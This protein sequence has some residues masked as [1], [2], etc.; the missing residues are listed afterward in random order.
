[1]DMNY[2]PSKPKGQNGYISDNSNED[3]YPI[4]PNKLEWCKFCVHYGYVGNYNACGDGSWF[5]VLRDGP[6]SVS[7]CGWCR[8]FMNKFSQDAAVLEYS[9]FKQFLLRGMNFKSD[10]V[11][12]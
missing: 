5:K 8:H 6:L 1:M 2:I 3:E 10:K 12:Q 9:K 4:D 7:Y 11:K